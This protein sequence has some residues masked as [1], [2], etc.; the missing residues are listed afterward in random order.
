MIDVSL[1][2]VPVSV[3]T[4]VVT[5]SISVGRLIL[6]RSVLTVTMN[7][8]YLNSVPSMSTAVYVLVN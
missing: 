1:Q 4:A 3:T 7:A 5:D 8:M 2:N 6:N